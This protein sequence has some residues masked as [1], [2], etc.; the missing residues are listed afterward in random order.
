M[1][2]RLKRAMNVTRIAITPPAPRPGREGIALVAILRNEA[3]FVG[4]W[5]AFHLRAGIRHFYVYD[6]GSSDGTAEVL[7][8]ALPVSALTV[9]PWDQRFRFG[10]WSSEIHNQILAYAHATRNF[11]GGYRWMTWI[12]A[13]E[14]LV[15]VSAE[16][17]PEALAPLEGCPLISLPWHMFGRCGHATMPDDGIVPNFLR[18]HP[19]PMRKGLLNFKMIADP[20]AVTA[21]KVHWMETRDGTDSCND[22]GEKATL[23]QREAPAFLSAE[24]VQ[25]NHYFTRSDADLAEKLAR[26]SN[27]TALS[28]KTRRTLNKVAL[29]ESKD[30]EDRRAADWWARNRGSSR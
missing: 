5:A 25:L 3:R 11:G 10:P 8:D 2:N 17:L 26:G 20:C 16:T 30:V 9:I 29:I 15:P 28:D 7:R 21:C 19:D 13:D 6:N 22:R 18:R 1:L 27:M 12:D 24:R 4:E 14:F 23:A